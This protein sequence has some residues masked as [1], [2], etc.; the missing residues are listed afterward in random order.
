MTL[1]E[2]K[3][4]KNEDEKAAANVLLQFSFCRIYFK[5]F[6]NECLSS[7]TLLDTLLGF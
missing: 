7:P 3:P 5:K 6:G 4:G 1:E 2:I